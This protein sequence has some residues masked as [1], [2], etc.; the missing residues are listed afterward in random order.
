MR[1]IILASAFVFAFLA[2]RQRA[3]LHPGPPPQITTG[4]TFSNEVVRI[5][6]NHC[7]TC[8]HPGDI[9]PFSL[10]TYEDAVDHTDAIKFM[11]QTRRMPPWKPTPACG[12]FAD[13]RVISQDEIDLIAKW[14]DNGAPAGNVA[15]L[16]PAKNFDGGWTLGQPDL[17]LSYSEPYTPPVTADMYRCFPMPTNLTADTYVSAIDIKP[18]DRQTVHHVIAYI[19]TSASGDSQK[20][21]DADPGPGYTSFGGPGF[22]TTSLSATLGGWAPGARPVVL[23]D[24]VAMSLPANSRIVLQVHYHPHSFKT[25]PDQTQIG[26]Y[27]AKK[28]PNKIV[29]FLPLINQ[30]FTIPPNDPNYLVSAEYN[31]GLPV[32]LYLI[33]PHMH[34]LGR[35][36][37]V[38]ATLPG[39]MEQCLINVDDWD[40]NWQG[41]YKFSEP[42]AIPSGTKLS[43]QAYYDNSTDNVRNPNNPPKAVSWGEQTTDEMCIAF[44]GFTIDGLFSK[45]QTVHPA[46]VFQPIE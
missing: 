3:V 41:Q 43:L 38:S 2:A 22:S 24:D 29:Y 13:A 23:P 18:G 16:P 5:F 44:L 10:M 45:S 8:H 46:Q 37:H 26:I 32:H 11:T 33:F 9:A 28:K 17:V 31:V 34:L 36:M 39:G 1:R 4:P 30:T 20:L 14:V 35:K 6:Q 7:Q 25:V 12:D 21:D 27:F 42:V 15:D 19:D 40:F